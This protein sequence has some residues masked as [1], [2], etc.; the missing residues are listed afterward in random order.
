MQRS[1][2]LDIPVKLI[3]IICILSLSSKPYDLFSVR[4]SFVDPEGGG[5][6]GP[7]PP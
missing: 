7:D 5:T 4:S 3:H 1:I 6:G 2:F